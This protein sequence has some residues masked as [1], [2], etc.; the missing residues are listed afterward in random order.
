MVDYQNFQN[1]TLCWCTNLVQI[2]IMKMARIIQREIWAKADYEAGKGRPTQRTF[3]DDLD[4]IV[5][6]LSF[7][8]HKHK[9]NHQF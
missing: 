1:I 8:N 4:H 5:S 6:L 2:W 3:E 7:L 9:I